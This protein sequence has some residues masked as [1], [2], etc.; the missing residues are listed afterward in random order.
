V[1]LCEK[2]N[3]N[4]LNKKRAKQLNTLMSKKKR[5]IFLT[6]N[7]CSI[8]QTKKLKELKNQKLSTPK[9]NPFKSPYR[10]AISLKNPFKSIKSFKS[11]F[12]PSNQKT[13]KTKIVMLSLSKPLY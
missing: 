3:L 4:P 9:G 5:C 2:K 12:N 6:C 10:E 13:K 8:P 7:P 11:V 1:S